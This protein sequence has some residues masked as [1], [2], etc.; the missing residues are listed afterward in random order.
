MEFDNSW[1]AVRIPGSATEFF[2]PPPPRPL[3]AESAFSVVNAWWLAELSRL[4]YRNDAPG[5]GLTRNRVLARV[6][7][8]ERV[9]LER[10]GTQCAIVEAGDGSREAPAVL[11]FRGTDGPVDWRRNS[12]PLWTR[13]PR[14]GRAHA[15]FVQA[16][17][18]V[19]DELESALS[20]VSA[21]LFYGGHS[22][23]GALALLTAG[24]RPP[25]AVYTFG[26]PRVGDAGFAESLEEEA[27]YRVVNRRDAVSRQP[28]SLP[29][30]RFRQ[31]G[32]LR[33]IA[34]GG[35]RGG[36]PVVAGVEPD[37]MP[38]LPGRRRWYDPPPEFCDH[39]P[40][41]YV[42]CLERLAAG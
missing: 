24:R 34:T 1:R 7:L 42:A 13:W 21:P 15:G 11:V 40:V 29:W 37:P 39:A 17:D 30:L 18:D 4:V 36:S 33:V 2:A 3:A 31:A 9:F 23:G 28:P 14:G 5:A 38:P 27:V 20:E 35:L 26:A 19:W 8:V 6:G 32:E 10:Q 41:N 12:N 25:L 22:L 16:L